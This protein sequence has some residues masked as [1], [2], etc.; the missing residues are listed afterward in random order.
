MIMML[1][2]DIDDDRNLGSCYHTITN[3]QPQV[4][5]I[6]HHIIMTYAVLWVLN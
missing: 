1:L 2:C 3:L 5:L 6:H 4:R